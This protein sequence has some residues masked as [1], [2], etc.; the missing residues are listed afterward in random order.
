V[1]EASLTQPVGKRVRVFLFSDCKGLSS[2][3]RHKCFDKTKHLNVVFDSASTLTSKSCIDIVDAQAS[4]TTA[5]W[6]YQKTLPSMLV[7]MFAAQTEGVDDNDIECLNSVTENPEDRIKTD[8]PKRD[9]TKYTHTRLIE[10]LLKLQNEYPDRHEIKPLVAMYMFGLFASQEAVT[11]KRRN[12]MGIGINLVRTFKSSN[13]S[14]QIERLVKRS[15]KIG[16]DITPLVG[17]IRGLVKHPEFKTSVLGMYMLSKGSSVDKAASDTGADHN[18]LTWLRTGLETARNNKLIS[19]KY[20]TARAS[21]SLKIIKTKLA[22]TLTSDPVKNKY[23]TVERKSLKRGEY[24][25]ETLLR[26]TKLMRVGEN[27]SMLKASQY[28]ASL[29]TNIPKFSRKGVHTYIVKKGVNYFI[30]F[31]SNRMTFVGV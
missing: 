1:Y 18:A 19:S 22:T 13:V 31:K 24:T 27:L 29:Q 12:L 28:G 10:E 30:K 17:A 2:V 20:Q 14:V 7:K 9:R 21:F 23:R 16:F 6:Q 26:E 3:T 5:V 11:E 15:K 8:T 25:E 4:T